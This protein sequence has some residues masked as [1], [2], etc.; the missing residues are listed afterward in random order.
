M[1]NWLANVCVLTQKRRSIFIPNLLLFSSLESLLGVHNLWL[2]GNYQCSWWD[3]WTL[4]WIFIHR[5]SQHSFGSCSYI[6]AS[7]Q[8]LNPNHVVCS[9]SCVAIIMS[10]ESSR[11]LSELVVAASCVAVI[12]L[13]HFG[14]YSSLASGGQD[15]SKFAPLN[16]S[17]I[18]FSS[19]KKEQFF[20]V[21]SQNTNHCNDCS[22][23]TKNIRPQNKCDDT[24]FISFF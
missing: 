8:I 21:C 23:L 9:A 22:N 18:L 2:C 24:F 1:L 12:M 4:H 14:W 7:W 15:V 10:K 11:R 6:L 17:L 13:R 16:P 3:P 19:P 5:F 20:S